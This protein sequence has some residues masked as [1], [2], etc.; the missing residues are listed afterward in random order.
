[1]NSLFAACSN[2]KPV[3]A[4]SI[5]KLCEKGVLDL[6]KMLADPAGGKPDP[7]TV[8]PEFAKRFFAA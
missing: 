1:M 3:F 4:C 2:A 8:W 6:M 5:L 7:V